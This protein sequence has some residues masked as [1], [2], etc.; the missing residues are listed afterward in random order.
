[1][2]LELSHKMKRKNILI[3]LGIFYGFLGLWSLYF[4]FD[5]LTSLTYPKTQQERLSAFIYIFF[6]R[7]IFFVM[8]TGVSGL[9]I[10]LSLFR[11]KLWGCKLA[12]HL[13]RLYII[14]LSIGFFIFLVSHGVLTLRFYSYIIEVPEFE[15]V[16]V[17]I[18][19]AYLT[20]ITVFLILRIINSFLSR[21]DVI[22]LMRD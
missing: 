5:Y 16:I 3:I 22:G 12:V 2:S 15:F 8:L 18:T 7:G 11:F 4:G 1:M 13:N 20:F 21:E 6:I 10:M 17:R 9:I 19:L 14:I